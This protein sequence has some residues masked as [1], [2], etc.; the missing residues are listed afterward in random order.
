VEL[1]E[2][3]RV[4]DSVWF[5]EAALAVAQIC[6]EGHLL[7]TTEPI[8][9]YDQGGAGRH[10]HRTS[11]RPCCKQISVGPR[12]RLDACHARHQPRVAGGSQGAFLSLPD[13]T[14]GTATL[15]C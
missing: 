6:S 14:V 4:S 8:C 15:Q 3:G 5:Y 13:L 12:R 1:L 7:R 2:V 10:Q 11:Q 9:K